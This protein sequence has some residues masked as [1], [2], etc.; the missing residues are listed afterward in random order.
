VS[1]DTHTAA[2]QRIHAMVDSIPPGCVA[3]YG[4]IAEEAGL[5][6]RARLVGRVLREL[7]ARTRLPWHRVVGAN[8]RISPRAGDGPELQAKRLR[9]EGVAVA[10]SGRL[11]LQRYRWAPEW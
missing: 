8:G 3:T 10:A 11:D 7:P 2:I 9:R 1:I 5:P 6:R 4:Q